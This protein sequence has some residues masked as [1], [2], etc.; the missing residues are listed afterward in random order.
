M[1]NIAAIDK[2]IAKIK[3]P[4][5]I[6]IL[7]YHRICALTELFYDRNVS[8]TPQEFRWQMEY[9]NE[10]YNVI[11][12]SRL[13]DYYEK[14]ADIPV[15][16]IVITFDDGFKDTIENAFPILKEMKL[17]AAV[18]PAVDFVSDSYIPWEDEIAYLV[19]NAN[20]D[21]LVV[22]MGELAKTVRQNDKITRDYLT[23]QICK[24]LRRAPKQERSE[25][26]KR[27]YRCSRF[28]E[29]HVR[30][31]LLTAKKV[32]MNIED[33]RIWGSSGMEVGSHTCSHPSLS[34]L[35]NREAE[36]ELLSSKMK[37]E[38]MTGRKIEAFAY[39]YGMAGYYGKNAIR[40]VRAAGYKCAVN[41]IDGINTS[42]SDKFDLYRM[43]VARRFDF[44][45]LCEGF[46]R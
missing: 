11:S 39:P 35:N 2:A 13:V 12:M 27:L 6:V 25:M 21:D 26:L 9:V 16:S 17:P 38:E 42:N 7:A 31:K 32:M 3:R 1:L 23:F 45:D 8:A 14:K 10:N 4:K 24:N 28:T 22:E 40:S 20:L 15:N 33:L 30:E 44:K 41:L 37:L 46:R 18:F 43:G 5:S 34:M 19:N 29:S 36:N